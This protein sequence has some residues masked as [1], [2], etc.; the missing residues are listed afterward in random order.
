MKW[1]II[2]F[3]FFFFDVYIMLKAYLWSKAKQRK[4]HLKRTDAK[5]HRY[6]DG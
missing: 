1:N 4:G 6:Q 3:F 5:G 2:F